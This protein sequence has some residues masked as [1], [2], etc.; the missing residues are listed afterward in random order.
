M[1]EKKH[2][3]AFRLDLR[4]RSTDYITT[5]N[6]PVIVGATQQM[7]TFQLKQWPVFFVSK[8]VGTDIMRP[9]SD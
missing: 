2:Q 3:E 5:A 1:Y 4:Y 6:V 7:A 8:L 9:V